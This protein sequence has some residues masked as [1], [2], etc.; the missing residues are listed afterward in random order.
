MIKVRQDN[1]FTTG[2]VLLNLQRLYRTELVYQKSPQDKFHI[3]SDGDSLDSL[4][5]QYYSNDKYWWIIY[6]INKNVLENPFD[7]PVGSTL[8]IPYL[9]RLKSGQ[10]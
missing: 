4:A 5:N 3:I 10:I 7:L 9:E 8:I 1:P 2:Y 6:D